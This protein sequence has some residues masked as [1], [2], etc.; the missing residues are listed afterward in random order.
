MVGKISE[1]EVWEMVARR[2]KISPAL[3]QHFRQGALSARRWNKE[4]AR[5]VEGLRPGIKRRS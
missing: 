4:L 1:T 2:W 3:F 5:F